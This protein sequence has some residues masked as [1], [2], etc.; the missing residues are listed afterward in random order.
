MLRNSKHDLFPY[1]YS[2]TDPRDNSVF[3][4][5]KGTGNRMYQHERSAR[6]G[7][8]G[9]S[10][11]TRII[12]DV[13]NAGFKVVCRVI[14]VC[15]THEQAFAAEKA[16][17]A[18]HKGLTNKTAGGGGIGRTGAENYRAVRE[19]TLSMIARVK[20]Y[21]DWQNEKP[22]TNQESDGYFMVVREM[23]EIVELCNRKL[24]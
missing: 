5:G 20:N 18:A 15:Q 10:D 7:K 14:E 21:I 4:I 19:Q 2:L 11:K 9:N 6:R 13:I 12:L 1:V 23:H 8:T 3:Y 16:H 24:A 17:I 22:R